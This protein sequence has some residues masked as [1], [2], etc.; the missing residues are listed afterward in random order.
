MKTQ[1]DT[2]KK[3][4]ALIKMGEKVLETTTEGHQKQYINEKKFH[5]FRISALSFLS[6]TFGEHSTFY[7]EFYKEATSP[8]PVRTERAIGILTAVQRELQ[9]DW[10]GS[11]RSEVFNVFERDMLTIAKKHAT[12]GKAKSAIVLAAS[13]LENHLQ[14]FSVEKGM[15]IMRDVDGQMVTYTAV[16]LNSRAYKKGLYERKVNKKI[17]AWLELYEK[18]LDLPNSE[19]ESE[20]IMRAIDGMMMFFVEHPT[21]VVE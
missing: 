18:C 1:S 7:K 13:L 10:L 9:G 5:D 11:I 3:V 19:I 17:F 20:P 21:K 2:D 4:I 8:T 12:A 15:S 16:Q 6:V 14:N